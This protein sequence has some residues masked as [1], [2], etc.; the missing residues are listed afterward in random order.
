M[1]CVS[2]P[3]GAADPVQIGRDRP[4]SPEP[5]A[6]AHD[7]ARPDREPAEPPVAVN[8]SDDV[9]RLARNSALEEAGTTARVGDYLGAV[10][11]DEVAVS[12]AFACVDRGYGGWYWSVTLAVVGRSAPTV[13]EVV[14]LPRQDALL[15]PPWVPWEQRI[16]AGDVGSGD[17]LPT[18]TDDIRLVPGYVYSD[19]PAV[20]EVAYEFGFG[21]ERV[22]SREGR[23]DAAERWHDG[24]FG[25][26]GPVALAAP[27]G[28]VT[29]AFYIP[30][31]GLLGSAFGGCANEFSP[32]DGRVVE[33][34]FGC[35]AHSQ[36]V[37][38]APLKSASTDTVVDELTLEVHF[39]RAAQ[40]PDAPEPA[41]PLDPAP[42][43]EPDLLAGIASDPVLDEVLEADRA[44]AA[45]PVAGVDDADADDPPVETDVAWT[46]LADVDVDADADA[47]A[48][49]SH[50]PPDE[51]DP[52]S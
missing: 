48:D 25:P 2:S 34:G 9:V 29:C 21:R 19:D 3:A 38:D 39:R 43:A 24:P 14:L 23:A 44:A 22:L 46:V 33:A 10:A 49:A 36:T 40:V 13:S 15:A 28:C 45:D 27:A 37:I 47:D 41:A 17:L 20:K 52:P 18:P 42:E 31:A 30:L 6:A 12:A 26:D 11:E 51:S 1:T 50:L 35:G 16:R 32:A 4:S 5:A 7:P 8:L